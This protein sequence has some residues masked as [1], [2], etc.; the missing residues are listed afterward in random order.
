MRIMNEFFCDVI[1]WEAMSRI[2]WP[3]KHGRQ[4]TLD[5]VF[6][7][8]QHDVNVEEDFD[9]ENDKDIEEEGPLEKKGK[10]VGT[11]RS[12]KPAW[13][14]LHKWDY[15]ITG[16]NGEERIKCLWCFKF[17][18]DTPFA[19]EVSITIQLSGLNVHASSEAHKCSIQLL[20]YES[21]QPFFPI[22]KHIE[23]MMYVKNFK[24]IS[25][26]ETMYFVVVRDLPLEL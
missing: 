1:Y 7:L 12:F 26:M 19:R 9:F 4:T 14:L 10:G 18:G 13:N 25:T 11:K 5:N 6:N 24:I 21:R 2:G 23:L 22:Q 17:K 15:P 20:E 3:K 16:P 8:S